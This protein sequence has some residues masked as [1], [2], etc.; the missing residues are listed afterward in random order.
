ML[1][2]EQCFGSDETAISK[3][4]LR[5]IM[6][7]Q[8]L[9]LHRSFNFLLQKNLRPNYFSPGMIIGPIET[10]TQAPVYLVLELDLHS[11]S[12]KFSFSLPA[13]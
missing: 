10:M 6:Q 13:V 5:L 12:K 3:L 4:D 2:T 7:Y 11:L 1:P 9:L 8:L